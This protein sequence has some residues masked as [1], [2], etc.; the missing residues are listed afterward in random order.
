MEV[1]GT[2]YLVA[3]EIAGE[4]EFGNTNRMNGAQWVA[5]FED[6][7]Q[8][9]DPVVCY[10]YSKKR[11]FRDTLI[12]IRERPGLVKVIPRT[13]LIEYGKVGLVQAVSR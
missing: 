13:K 3:V 8:T 9:S 10:D 5:A 7:V 12:L 2:R 4:V 1:T 6:A 11:N